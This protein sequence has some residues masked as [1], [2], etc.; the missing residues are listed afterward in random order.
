MATYCDTPRV[1]FLHGCCC[2]PYCDFLFSPFSPLTC[3]CVCLLPM[4]QVLSLLLD[5]AGPSRTLSMV[6]YV[7][8][9]LLIS[10]GNTA[11]IGKSASSLLL[12]L[13]PH[14][15]VSNN[16]GRKYIWQFLILRVT[17]ARTVLCVWIGLGI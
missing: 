17:F 11:N 12:I 10:I 9:Q 4:H 15:K 6:P 16:A 7:V 13:L 1:V 2:L 3:T 5:V 14:H 8:R